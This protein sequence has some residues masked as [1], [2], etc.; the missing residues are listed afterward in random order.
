MIQMSNSLQKNSKESNIQKSKVVMIN[1]FRIIEINNN[2]TEIQIQNIIKNGGKNI[3]NN[4]ESILSQSK[5][6]SDELTFLKHE[7][8]KEFF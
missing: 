5:I 6:K 8:F 1:N 4:E 2:M 3:L 7:E